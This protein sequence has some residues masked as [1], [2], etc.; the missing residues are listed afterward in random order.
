MQCAGI[1]PLLAVVGD[2]RCSVL[3]SR[4][5]MSASPALQQP[6]RQQ[7]P[8]F[9]AVVIER[10][11]V[12]EIGEFVSCSSPSLTAPHLLLPQPRAGFV[13]GRA[14]ARFFHR[15]HHLRVVAGGWG[16]SDRCGRL[17][18]LAYMQVTGSILLFCFSSP[19]QITFLQQP[20]RFRL[21]HRAG[22]SPLVARAPFI[23]DRLPAADVCG[24]GEFG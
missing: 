23:A 5:I 21:A 19:S 24:V 14:C 8:A 7:R 1:D 4:S 20:R 22:P 18:A 13:R 12:K 3:H 16:A 15:L 9:S 2:L 11:D 10:L 6:Q 17:P